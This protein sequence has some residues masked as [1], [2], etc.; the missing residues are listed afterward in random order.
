MPKN[1]RRYPLTEELVRDILA[2]IRAGSFP[3]VAAEAAGLPREVFDHLLRLGLR[4]GKS[5]RDKLCRKLRDGVMQAR[6]QARL[7]AEV[8]MLKDDPGRWLT[9]GPGRVTEGSP[10][11]SVPVKAVPRREHPQ[12]DV[13]LHPELQGLFRG[14]LE[15]LSPYPDARS[16]VVQA[17]RPKLPG[18]RNGH[19]ETS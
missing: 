7:A 12:V 19:R 8:A 3:H 13:L 16:V 4:R 14:L 2:F 18:D 17:L 1:S 11:W 6:A 9:Q 15:V 10:G 5:E